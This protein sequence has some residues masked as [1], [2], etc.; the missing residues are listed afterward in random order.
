MTVALSYQIQT[1]PRVPADDARQSIGRLGRQAF[2][3][4]LREKAAR[5]AEKRMA[6]GFYA[7]SVE[8]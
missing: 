5:A 6:A 7:L 1:L 8:R 4:R 2:Q 3:R